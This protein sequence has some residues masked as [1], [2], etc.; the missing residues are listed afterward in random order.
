M[1]AMSEPILSDFPKLHCPFIRQTF[2]VNRE[3]WSRHGSRLGLRQWAAW[4]S[5]A[6]LSLPEGRYGSGT[7]KDTVVPLSGLKIAVDYCPAGHVRKPPGSL[8]GMVIYEHY[9]TLFVHP[10]NPQ[11]LEGNSQPGPAQE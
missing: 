1:S 6:A 5:R 7:A 8:P 4:F 9:Q 3:Q 10:L 2:P 11:A